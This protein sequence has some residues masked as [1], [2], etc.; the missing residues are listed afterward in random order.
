MAGENMKRKNGFTLVELLAVIVLLA[1]LMIIAI[2][3]AFKLASKV[4]GKAYQTKV[5]L[6]EK[7][8]QEF[9]Q[10]NLKLVRQGISITNSTEHHSCTF[11]FDNKKNI[12]GVSYNTKMY[13]E[14][15]TLLDE[16]NRKEYW[17]TR[18]TVSDLVKSNNLEWDYENQCDGRCN[19]D[20][21]KLNYD[22]TVIDPENNY[23]MNSCHVYLYYRN[24]RVYTYFDEA[25]CDNKSDTPNND[26]RE[27]RPLIG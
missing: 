13:S 1:L 2:P 11:N 6:I 22:K 17:C 20:Q 7:A 9:G 27:Y 24:S 26:G 14:T 23:I 12:T 21:D 10:S 18:V 19:T 4:K 16:A 5:D 25:T 3:N 15:A 8:G